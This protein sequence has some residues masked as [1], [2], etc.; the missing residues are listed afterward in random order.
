MSGNGRVVD[1]EAGTVPN[2]NEAARRVLVDRPND[3]RLLF[4]IPIGDD[5]PIGSTIVW[6]PRHAWWPGHRVRKLS[7][8][9]DPDAPLL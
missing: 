3:Q 6:G 8:E 4:Y 2:T 5:P 7:N 1:V 9:I